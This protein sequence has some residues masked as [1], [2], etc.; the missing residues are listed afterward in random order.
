MP[1]R[2][3]TIPDELLD[4]VTTDRL[5][6]VSSVGERG[7]LF[8]HIMWIDWDGKHLLL[9]SPTDS[10][11]GRNWRADPHAGISVVDRVNPF[12]YVQASGRVTDI[13]PDI[14]LAQI[15][16]LSRRYTGT[17]YHDREGARETFAITLDRVRASLG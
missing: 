6:H 7:W 13:R 9:N 12:R 8:N 10:F 2:I 11:K 3:V 17:D 5:A 15:D 16:R 4:L 14:G 1:S